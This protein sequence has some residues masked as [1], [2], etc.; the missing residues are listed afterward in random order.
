[1]KNIKQLLFLSILCSLVL[2]T[3]CG[4]DEEEQETTTI[5]TG[6]SENQDL[7]IGIL[8]LLGQNL[9]LLGQILILLGKIIF[10]LGKINFPEQMTILEKILILCPCIVSLPLYQSIYPSDSIYAL[11]LLMDRYND[12][13]ICFLEHGNGNV[14]RACLVQQILPRMESFKKNR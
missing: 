14:K 13:S 7:L 2:F 6:L 8:F 10:L 9:I 4:E 1:M 5:I 12:R 11:I 3:N